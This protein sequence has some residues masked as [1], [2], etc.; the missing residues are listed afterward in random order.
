MICIRTF[1]LIISFTFLFSSTRAQSNDSIRIHKLP[2]FEISD[3]EIKNSMTRMNEVEDMKVLAGKKNE[4][5][6][7]KNTNADLSINNARQIFSKVPGLNVWE[8]D[9]SGIQTS[10]ST[11]GLSPNR[12][13]EFNVR[14]NGVDISSDVFGYPEAYFT[15][16]TEAVEK[17]EI[18]RGAASLQFGPQFGGLINYVIKKAPLDK[19]VLFET[20]Q[21]IGAYGLVN[22]Y[23]S[24]GITKEKI[25]FFGYFHNR[26]AKG[27]RENSQYDIGTGYAS[28]RLTPSKRFYSE[29]QYTRMNYQSQQPGGLTDSLFYANPRQSLRSRNWMSTPWNVFQWESGYSFNENCRI[30][31]TVFA[32]EAERNSIGVL[33]SIATPDTINSNLNSF[34]PRQI[35]R[36]RYST[37]GTELR[38]ISNWKLFNNSNTLASGIR[39]YRSNTYRRA[40]GTG[41]VGNEFNLNLSKGTWGRSLFFQTHNQAAFLENIFRISSRL[42]ITPG[43]RLEQITS[44]AEGYIKLGESGWIEPTQ[45]KRTQFLSGL[46]IEYKTGKK[47]SLYMNFSQNFRPV[48]FSELTP[49]ATTD[50]IDQELKNATGYNADAGFRGSIG[51]VFRYDANVFYLHYDNRIGNILLNGNQFRTNIGTS[52][53]K[54]VEI[55]VEANPF[56]LF[57]KRDKLGLLSVFATVS[58]IDARYSRWDDESKLNDPQKTYVNRRVEN[59]PQYIHRLGLSYSIKHFSFSYQLSSVG[60]AFADALNTENPNTSATNGKIPAYT[61]SDITLGFRFLKYYS[62]RG[63]INNFTDNQYFTRRAGGYP[64]PGILP[65]MGRTWFISLGVNL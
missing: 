4:V 47:S 20:Q 41:S 26:T 12:S 17:I 54:G 65:G 19:P 14:Q 10:I 22:Q 28:I 5:I 7:L 21:T 44:T 13:W 58:F 48:T 29:I 23:S 15:P 64:G 2:V 59:A 43:I 16:P 49:S 45:R 39:V 9:G 56:S 18:I 51:E 38:F 8:N 63:G 60:D 62:L 6:W 52:Y 53:S 42:T 25:S 3:Y 50:S 61:V 11:R 32:L 57:K 1:F 36:D 27:W 24:L 33:G 46:G 40:L 31:L 37:L 30:K 35:D 34:N 55:Y